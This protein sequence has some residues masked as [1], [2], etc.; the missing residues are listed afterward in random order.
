[1]AMSDSLGD[2]RIIELYLE[3]LY[4]RLSRLRGDE[5]VSNLPA[6]RRTSE[7]LELSKG[8]RDAAQ[9]LRLHSERI[10]VSAPTD[11]PALCTG[12]VRYAKMLAAE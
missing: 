4:G 2:S 11:S 10:R 3:D 9:V 1:M 8:L 5:Q 7:L 6:A 12:Q